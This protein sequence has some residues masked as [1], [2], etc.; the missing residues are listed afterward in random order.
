MKREEP[1]IS[2]K[3]KLSK[4]IRD[5]L[6][7]T[8]ILL[9]ICGIMIFYNGFETQ[10]IIE[11]EKSV[12]RYNN[13]FSSDY[14][15]N[16]KPNPFIVEPFL[17]AGQTYISDLISGID[18]KFNYKYQ[19]YASNKMTYKYRIDSKI[20]A[21]YRQNDKEY[22][23]LD[24]T[25]NLKTVSVV[26]TDSSQVNI[27]DNLLIDYAKYHEMIKSFKQKMGMNIE[28]KLMINMIVDTTANIDGKEVQNQ[29]TSDYSITLGDKI[30]RVD[31]KL[32]DTNTKTSTTEGEIRQEVKADSR[33]L[34]VGVILISIGLYMAYLILFKTQNLHAI[35]NEF[36][37]ELNHILKSCQ[38]RIVMVENLIDS[39]IE[40][41]II[42]KDFGELIKLSEELYK[43]ILCYMPEEEKAY[44][45]IISNRVKYRYILG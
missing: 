26:E 42:V 11:K 18:M 24:K 21:T 44:F 4:T 40:H 27:Q 19:D 5:V 2:D 36:K 41:T 9:M 14:K 35:K 7:G 22:V 34:V 32:I 8:S 10:D 3:V 17:P 15:V 25:E 23:V 13:Q 37:L 16:L 20:Q 12:Y 38:D 45:S 43:P 29:Y 1:R 28:A 31:A 39:D 33:K 30:S 6:L